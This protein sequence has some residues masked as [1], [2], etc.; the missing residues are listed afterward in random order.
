MSTITGTHSIVQKM[1]KNFESNDFLKAQ[2]QCLC[3]NA[4]NLNIF[5][6]LVNFSKMFELVQLHNTKV[7]NKFIHVPENL[8]PYIDSPDTKIAW[9]KID[10]SELSKELLNK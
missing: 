6:S 1:A 7:L 3:R 4:Y 10:N 9:K 8:S 5:S 2:F